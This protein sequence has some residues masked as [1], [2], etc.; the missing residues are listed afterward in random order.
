MKYIS[1]LT[2]LGIMIILVSCN[3]DQ[4]ASG[5]ES[6][7]E[8]VVQA[9]NYVGEK[10]TYATDSTTMIGYV[11]YDENAPEPA[12]GI[13]VVHE[14]WGHNDYA[15]MRADMLARLG[16]VALAVDMYG[17]GKT[18]DHPDDAGKFAMSVMH[19][20]DNA[21]A[22]FNAAVDALKAHPK[23]DPASLGAIGY[24]FGGGIVLA[25][26]NAGADLDAVVSFHGSVAVPVKPV[27]G[28]KTRILV[29]N[30]ADDPFVTAEQI[31]Q[32]KT[33]MDAVGA[34]YEFINYEGAKHSFT[35]K[36]ADENGAKFELPLA[37]NAAADSASW[38]KMESLFT[39]VFK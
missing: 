17:D 27:E 14:W 9:P 34:S 21:Q 26:A 24:C 2:L 36:E 11:A 33:A 8:E 29:C 38:A 37:Y 18:A 10:L 15:K 31:D 35:S 12:P 20:F 1:Y 22:R 39:E 32:Y 7:S 3:S 4:P 30:G 16:Y 28:L 23:V 6:A 5:E 25:M 13:L 19:D